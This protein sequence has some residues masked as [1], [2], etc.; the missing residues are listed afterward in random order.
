[1]LNEKDF[2]WLTR[3]EN[4]IVENP[5]DC[6]YCIVDTGDGTG[7]MYIVK[8]LHAQ[9]TDGMVKAKQ[10]YKYFVFLDCS[11]ERV[12]TDQQNFPHSM[13]LYSGY[14]KVS[15]ALIAVFDTLEEAKLRAY[16]QY[17]HHYGYVLPHVVDDTTALTRTHF[18]VE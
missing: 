8:P 9:N 5:V 16:T 4:N 15:E 3:C 2:K 6:Y 18:I 7:K 1:M 14:R 10:G 17:A 13:S 12:P 11:V